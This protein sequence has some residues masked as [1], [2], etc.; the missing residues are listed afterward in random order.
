MLK[1]HRRVILIMVKGGDKFYNEQL[2]AL[3]N[4]ALMKLE[5]NKIDFYIIILS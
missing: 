4:Y 1:N 2:V 5:K 3:T